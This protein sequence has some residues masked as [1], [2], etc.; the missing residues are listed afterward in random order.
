LDISD[1]NGRLLRID[2][3]I[4]LPDRLI[5]LDYKLSIP[6]ASSEA[7]RKYQIQMAVYRQAVSLLRPEKNVQSYLLSANGEVLEIS[8]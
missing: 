7:F 5:I 3:L 2:R 6:E 1:E 8:V 4:E